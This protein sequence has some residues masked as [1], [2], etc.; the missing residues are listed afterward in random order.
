[1]RISHILP[2]VLAGLLLGACQS[3]PSPQPAATPGRL[4][5]ELIFHGKPAKATDSQL[6]VAVG[7]IAPD[8]TLPSIDG[9]SVRLS[10]FRGRKHVVLSFVP[11]AFTPVC[12]EQWP[13]YGFVK[14]ELLDKHD[15]VLL[16]I[17]VDN[18]PGLHAWVTGMGG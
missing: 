14:A 13:G 1:M 11:A 4:P 16:G 9:K 6:K 2:G 3:P 10:S 5:P 12:S 7:Q 18:L 8:F 15:A 17:T